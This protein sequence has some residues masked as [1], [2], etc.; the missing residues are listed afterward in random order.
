MVKRALLENKKIY[1]NVKIIS[2]NPFK[3]KDLG[4]KEFKDCILI[5]DEAGIEISN[6]DWRNNLSKDQINFLKKHRHYNVD[7]YLFSQTYNDVDNKFRDL[8]T[9]LYLLKPSFIPFFV[10]MKAIRKKI[11]IIDGK[12]MEIYEWSPNENEKIFM[13]DTWAYFNSYEKDDPLPEPTEIKYLK[14]E[15]IKI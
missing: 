7:I 8:T 13:P 15:S 4:K 5:I 10:T 11:D 2:A 14:S 3:L 6:R 1:S 9:K 12:I